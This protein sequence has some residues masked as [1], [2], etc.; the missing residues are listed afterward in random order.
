MKRFLKKKWLIGVVLAALVLLIIGI[1]A[2]ILAAAA[3]NAPRNP[4]ANSNGNGY[5][6]SSS[7]MGPGMM[8]GG[9]NGY[10]NGNS[11]GV[12]SNSGHDGF[13]PGSGMGVYGGAMMSRW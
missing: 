8:Q 6:P 7:F 10:A 9:R 4:G 11:S 1:T 2:P 5:W 13:G 3:N 12:F